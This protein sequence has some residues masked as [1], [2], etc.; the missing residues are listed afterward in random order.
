M[1]KQKFPKVKNKCRH[2]AKDR[3]NMRIFKLI[4]IL[5]VL[6]VAGIYVYENKSGP[7]TFEGNI[8]GT[9]YRIKVKTP[10]K[11]SSLSDKIKTVLNRVN[12]RM[13]VFESESEISKINRAGTETVV[14]SPE[15]SYLLYHAEEVFRK[16]GGAF[17]PT[18]GKLVSL[19][20][21]GPE[22]PQRIPDAKEIDEALKYAGFDKLMF[23]KDYTKLRKKFPQTELN[24]SAIAKGYA[25]DEV[26]R[27]LEENGYKDYMIEIG[28]EIKTAG[29][30]DDRGNLWNIGLAVPEKNSRNN[31]MVLELTDVGIATSGDYRNFF[32]K[33]GKKYAHTILPQTGRPAEND[34]ASATV[35][36]DSCMLADAYATAIMALGGQKGM[37]FAEEQNLPV[38]LII[39]GAN[40][41]MDIKWSSSAR[42]LIGE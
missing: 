14:L 5:L 1:L 30:K 28:G 24:L 9:S 16:S 26:A 39:R 41:Q 11:D 10:E 42:K 38:I 20:G 27:L 40:G 22:H 33:D 19:W 25:V 8:F 21:F 15:M 4:S 3:I 34:L 13:S 31:L 23:N 35:F 37:L 32:Q 17:D 2:C 7:Q 12:T 18:V 36:H 29:T 6:G